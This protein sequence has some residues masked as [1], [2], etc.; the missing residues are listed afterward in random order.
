VPTATTGSI[1]FDANPRTGPQ[2]QQDNR[3]QRG[4]QASPSRHR[5]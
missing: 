1:F 4:R 5:Q 3:A 2:D